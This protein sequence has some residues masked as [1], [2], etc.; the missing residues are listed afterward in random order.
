MCPFEFALACLAVINTVVGL[1][2]G[3]YFGYKYGRK[4]EARA[5]LLRVALIEAA[6]K[7][8]S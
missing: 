6:A 8:R 5:T 3:G 7:A 2:G 1:V 4:L